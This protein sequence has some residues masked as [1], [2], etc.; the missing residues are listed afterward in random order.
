MSWDERRYGGKNDRTASVLGVPQLEN[1]R[2]KLFY[3]IEER[4]RF[5]NVH[6]GYFNDAA[7]LQVGEVRWK[8]CWCPGSP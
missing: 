8:L 7:V 6:E 1:A 3:W 5:I 2:L 4:G